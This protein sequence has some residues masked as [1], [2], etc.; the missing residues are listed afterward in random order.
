MTSQ[1]PPLLPKPST[2]R[3]TPAAAVADVVDVIGADQPPR[4]EI[5]AGE[6]PGVDELRV[7]LWR[8]FGGGRGGGFAWCRCVGPQPVSDE[9]LFSVARVQEV[10]RLFEPGLQGLDDGVSRGVR[11]TPVRSDLAEVPAGSSAPPFTRLAQRRV[12]AD[13]AWVV[14]RALLTAHGSRRCHA[15]IVW[16]SA[17]SRRNEPGHERGNRAANLPPKK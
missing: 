14:A 11:A 6:L 3:A 2:R 10:V 5:P 15:W 1:V 16:W 9:G 17:W 13:R 4:D 8:A 7:E 12:R